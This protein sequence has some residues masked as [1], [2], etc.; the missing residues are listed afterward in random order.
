MHQ[1]TIAT[2]G[3]LA[4]AQWFLNVGVHNSPH[5]AFVDS[6]ADAVECSQRVDWLNLRQEAMNQYRARIVERDVDR[7]RQW[8]LIV[9]EVK[10]ETMPLVSEK[11]KKT[12]EINNLPKSFSDTVQWDILNVCMESEYADVFPPGFYANQAY[13]YVNGHFPCGW[14]GAFPKGR[15][16]VY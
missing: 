5:P 15:P 9:R 2:L 8:N 10:K 14:E 1:R 16:I 7:F 13:W 11:I 12:V 3:E 6:W 4:G